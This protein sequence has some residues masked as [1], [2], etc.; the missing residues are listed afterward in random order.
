MKIDGQ[1]KKLS[2]RK[3]YP[4]YIVWYD[5]S[6]GEGEVIAPE[7]GSFTVYLHS[8]CIQSDKIDDNFENANI[9]V[10]FYEN[11]YSIHV[12]KL[13]ILDGENDELKKSLALKGE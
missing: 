5:F 3:R 13:Y 2:K 12:D 7:L 4:A 10:T 11:L 6:S 1:F 9:E 8:S